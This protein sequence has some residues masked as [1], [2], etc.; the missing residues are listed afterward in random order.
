MLFIAELEFYIIENV[1]VLL[2][3]SALCQSCVKS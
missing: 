2:Q 3:L 1:T